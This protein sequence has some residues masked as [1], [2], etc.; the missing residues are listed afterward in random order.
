MTGEFKYENTLSLEELRRE[1]RFEWDQK[2]A[3]IAALRDLPEVPP[4]I[5][6]HLLS[7]AGKWPDDNSMGKQL[8]RKHGLDAIPPKS[9]YETGAGIWS[10]IRGGMVDSDRLM[11]AVDHV[12]TKF[13]QD[14]QDGYRS[15]DRQFAIA[16]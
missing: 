8:Q 2:Y 5:V 14:E 12:L 4:V 16:I 6:L 7:S 3:V 9:E 1:I 13:K 11:A 10:R 15:R